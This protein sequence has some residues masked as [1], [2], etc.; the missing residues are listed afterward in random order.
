MLVGVATG[1]MEAGSAVTPSLSI[2]MKLE[3]RS[4]NRP[5]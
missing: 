3:N 1:G 2:K 4:L 5:S